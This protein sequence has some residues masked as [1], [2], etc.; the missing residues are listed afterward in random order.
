MFEGVNNSFLNLIL[1][2]TNVIRI[3]RDINNHGKSQ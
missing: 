2:L 3:F 1:Y